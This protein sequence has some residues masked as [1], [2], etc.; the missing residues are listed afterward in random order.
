MGLHE[1]QLRLACCH[2][3]CHVFCIGAPTQLHSS[4]MAVWSARP[5]PMSH[6]HLLSVWACHA[7][8]LLADN[9]QQVYHISMHA[10]GPPPGVCHASMLPPTLSSQTQLPCCPSHHAIPA[11][12]HST[13]P[14]G[15]SSLRMSSQKHRNRPALPKACGCPVQQVVDVK[16]IC[17]CTV[18]MTLCPCIASSTMCPGS[19]S[20]LTLVVPAVMLCPPILLC[21]MAVCPLMR[22]R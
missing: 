14:A 20:C 18:W 13:S 5:P 8:R 22:T 17:S 19:C 9:Q 7:S 4:P 11:A 21:C 3:H 10:M 1:Q 6:A 15:Q 2:V 12:P 16:R